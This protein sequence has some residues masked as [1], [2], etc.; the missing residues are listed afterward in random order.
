MRRPGFGSNLTFSR[1]VFQLP[2]AT[3]LC[4]LFLAMRQ[5]QFESLEPL[6]TWQALRHGWVLSAQRRAIHLREPLGETERLWDRSSLRESEP[7]SLV[8]PQPC[9]PRERLTTGSGEAVA[10]VPLLRRM[11]QL[12]K[13]QRQGEARRVRG[14][15]ADAGQA[16]VR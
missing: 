11:L 1:P 12:Q 8:S 9:K 5:N 7:A 6:V 13:P 3:C 2:N 10:A 4:V 15:D 16:V 14:A